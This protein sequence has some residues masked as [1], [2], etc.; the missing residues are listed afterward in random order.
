MQEAYDEAKRILTEKHRQLDT[1]ANGVLEFEMLTGEEM[2]VLPE[3]RLPLRESM[4]VRSPDDRR[5]IVDPSGYDSKL[6]HY[7]SYRNCIFPE[8]HPSRLNGVG[9]ATGRSS[10]NPCRTSQRRPA[11]SPRRKRRA[12]SFSS[13]R[14]RTNGP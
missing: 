14:C 2:K 5:P 13:S 12:A 6:L 8:S 10:V 1:L 7:C 9:C 11:S 4:E 3:G